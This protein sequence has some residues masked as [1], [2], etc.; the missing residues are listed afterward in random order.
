[1]DECVLSDPHVLCSVCTALGCGSCVLTGLGQG[2]G[3]SCEVR[4]LFS[5]EE[6]VIYRC[7]SS[8]I[9]ERHGP[10]IATITLYYYA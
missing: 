9:I 8:D 4:C 5:E 2:F 3:A 1:M 7:Y 10:S 6:Q